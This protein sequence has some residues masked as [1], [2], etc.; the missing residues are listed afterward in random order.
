MTHPPQRAARMRLPRPWRPRRSRARLARRILVPPSTA[1][2]RPDATSAV[3]RKAKA[4]EQQ[5]KSRRY[6]VHREVDNGRPTPAY[7]D[8]VVGLKGHTMYFLCSEGKI[9]QMGLAA[10]AKVAHF[11][12]SMN[13][14]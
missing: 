8:W 4:A 14:C 11:K 13:G 6:T 12:L 9:Y 3:T 2:T 5:I 1:A 10:N 7:W